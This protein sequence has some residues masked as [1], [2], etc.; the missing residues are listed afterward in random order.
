MIYNIY[1]QGT[2]SHSTLDVT[3]VTEKAAEMSQFDIQQRTN[4]VYNIDIQGSI[5]VRGGG[6]GGC[7]PP[8]PPV[9]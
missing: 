2:K 6:L 7:R 9:L 1:I 5:S 3:N 4:C 8:P